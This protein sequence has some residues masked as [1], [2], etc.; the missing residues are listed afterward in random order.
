MIGEISLYGVYVP[1]L[2]LLTLLA[3]IASRI[4]IHILAHAGFYRFVWHPALFDFALFIITLC[5]FAFLSS[6]WY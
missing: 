6:N 5:V 1:A 2:L 4:L 3:F